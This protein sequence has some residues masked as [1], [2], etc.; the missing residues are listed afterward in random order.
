MSSDR[1]VPPLPPIE[2]GLYQ[3]YKGPLYKVLGISRHSET[4]E[5]L[6]IYHPLE[7]DTSLWVRPWAMFTGTVE[8]DGQTVPR[9]KHL[10]GLPPAH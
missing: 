1:P 4:L 10:D 9:F 3:H 5:P 2:V 7:G 6:V 8:V